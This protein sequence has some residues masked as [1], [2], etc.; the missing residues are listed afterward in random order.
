MTELSLNILDIANNSV[1]AEAENIT[2]KICVDTIKNLLEIVIT[3]DGCGMSEELLARVT[4]PFSTTRTTRKVG[5]GIPFFKM[6]AEMCDGNFGIKSKVGVGTEIFATY[7]LDHIDRQPLGDV[8]STVTVL[9]GGAPK[10]NI[11]LTYSFDGNP[12]E[13][14]S[15]EIKS[16]L[17]DD[18]LEDTVALNYIKDMIN[19]NIEKINGGY[20]V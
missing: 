4:D 15:N 17:G 16:T 7:R 18:A 8:G 12:F 9:M 6:G 11:K 1:R 20:I 14:S 19:E 2:V 3:D 13:I 10:T 5:M